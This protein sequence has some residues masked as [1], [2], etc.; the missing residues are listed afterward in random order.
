[1]STLIKILTKVD[2]KAFELAPQFNW[3]ERK[4]YFYPSSWLKQQISNLDD[5]S[6]TNKIVFVLMFGYFQ[7][8]KRFVQ[9]GRAHV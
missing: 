3:V 9:I 1:M 4:K 8:V 2:I 5:K 6:E 7:A